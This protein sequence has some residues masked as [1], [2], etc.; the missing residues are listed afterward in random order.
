[1]KVFLSGKLIDKS[2]IFLLDLLYYL[3]LWLYLED[4]SEKNLKIG[5]NLNDNN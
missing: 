5:K 2:L 3:F 4:T 1:M